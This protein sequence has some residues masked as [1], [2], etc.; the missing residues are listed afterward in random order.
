MRRSAISIFSIILI[1]FLAAGPVSQCIA[2]I[3]TDA[4]LLP[5]TEG[6]GF[7]AA[8][9]SGKISLDLKGM[10]VI[11][12]IKMLAAKG[13]LNIVLGG[14]VKGRVTIFLKSV[15]LMDAF[16]IILIANNLAYDK[17]GDIIY[18][19]N[20]RDYEKI[21][22]ERY[23]EKKD[24][25]I[26]RLK[27]SK[28][29]EVSKA[30]NQMKSKVGKI[31]VD[32]GSNTIVAI[33]NPM[34]LVR[35]N[36]AIMSIDIPTVTRIFE[37]EYS[38]VA[39]MKDK[40]AE[41]LTKGIGTMQIDERTNKI[42]VTDLEKKIKDIERV[43]AAFD[44]KPQQ[45]LIEAKIVQITLDDRFKLGVEW[46]SVIRQLQKELSLKSA[47]QL[48]AP[49]LF[50]PP[51][52]ELVLGAMGSGDVNVMI[53][54]LKTIG[55]TN[56]LSSPRVTAINNQEAKILIGTSQPY[57]TNTVTQTTGT[58]TTG[59]NISFIDVGVKLYVTPTITKDGYITM[60]IRPEVS[61]S[62][63]NYSY[64]PVPQTTVPIV[65]TTQAETSVSIK[66]GTTIII[67]G[68]I[69]DERTETVNKIP[70]LGDLPVIKSA[71]SNTDK[72]VQKQELVIFLTPHIIT[73]DSDYLEQPKTPTIGEDKFTV[74]EQ[75]AFERRTPT[76]MKPGMF[77]E[78]RRDQSAKEYFDE[79]DKIARTEN[80]NVAATS[81]EYYYNVKNKIIGRIVVP[82]D[83]KYS[84]IRG[85]VKISFFLTPAGKIAR[86]PDIIES[87]NHTLDDL[88]LNAV[89]KAGPF[90]AFPE[91]M[92]KAEKRFVM[93][94]AFE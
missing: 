11:E 92:G 38:K 91:G 43:V 4:V 83:T 35:M 10:D 23:A 50:G 70:L 22:G 26:F 8:Q 69:K 25:M 65:Q 52:A 19:M 77:K 67:G 17:R 73:G 6:A 41:N 87:S 30:L 57:A 24:V 72:R 79:K 94:V 59:T 90:P 18:V 80:I 51:G 20:Q 53:Q 49:G 2:D 48:A 82:K 88:A 1:Y 28:A 93:D 89:R 61:S 21:Y 86:G 7:Q 34:V 33:D 16:E 66:D 74:S 76:P 46:D 37:L 15:N 47:F 5:V 85:K 64:G 62:S 27:Y 39:D 3:Q 29:V 63:S 40:V 78:P 12:V 14:D 45:V 84:G 68:L 9:D 58:A 54:V 75:S 56:L 36:D 44:E 42:V 31:I 60:K 13:N 32:E 55:D 81:G 71:F